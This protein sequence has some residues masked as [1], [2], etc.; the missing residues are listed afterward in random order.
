MD[1]GEVAVQ[2]A[3]VI[4][5]VTLVKKLT[6]ETL[7]EWYMLFAVGFAFAIVYLAIADNFI[8]IEFIKQSLMVGLSAAGV[9]NIANKIGN[10]T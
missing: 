4:A 3:M 10:G 5:L 9:Y 7:G 8:L 1:W 6:K 2:V